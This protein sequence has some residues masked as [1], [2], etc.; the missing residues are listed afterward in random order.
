MSKLVVSRYIIGSKKNSDRFRGTLPCPVR[1]GSEMRHSRACRPA[2]G[3]DGNELVVRAE[4][5]GT[6]PPRRTSP[7]ASGVGLGPHRSTGDRHPRR[8]RAVVSPPRVSTLAGGR[9]PSSFA[10]GQR[11]PG[12]ADTWLPAY[13]VGPWCTRSK[14]RAWPATSTARSA[15]FGR[16]ARGE[17][18]PGTRRKHADGPR[19]GCREEMPE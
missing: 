9:A 6:E 5:R 18:A 4:N 13:T 7:R 10:H 16:A 17:V 15:S 3:P 1:E 11:R 14:S 19:A 8:S 12:V 2:H